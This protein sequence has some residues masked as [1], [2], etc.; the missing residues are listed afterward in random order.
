MGPVIDQWQYEAFSRTE[1][2]HGGHANDAPPICIS[3]WGQSLV[4]F[5]ISWI[6]EINA[7]T[8]SL[9]MLASK[10]KIYL[11]LDFALL[12]HIGKCRSSS[13]SKPALHISENP[14]LKCTL[15]PN[16]FV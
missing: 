12:S 9:Q 1:R 3:F 15:F 14:Y 10:Q 11:H 13:K 5:L 7:V 16:S 8:G 2:H 6:L 4:F